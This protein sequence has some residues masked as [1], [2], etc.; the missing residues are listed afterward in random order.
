[1]KTISLDLRERILAAY[2]ADEG[3]REAV[4]RRF[5]VSLGMVKKLLQQRRR[6]GDVRP[7]HHRS[8]R[9]PCIVA[10]HQQQLRALLDKKPDLTLK[11]L[12]G[13]TGL[14]CTLPAIHYVLVRL[15]LTYKKRRSRPASKT[16]PTS[17]ARGG[18]GGGS[19]PAGIR[20]GWS[21]S[22]NRARRQ[23]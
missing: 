21:S 18:A 8:G 23:T 17:G 2:D 6:L 9:K 5:R 20:P 13:A 14:R 10:S 4:A 11:E 3:T 12:R 15:G 7:Q 19:K 22:T 1:V 16:G